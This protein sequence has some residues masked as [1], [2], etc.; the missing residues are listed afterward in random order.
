M[1]EA[2]GHNR[3][4]AQDEGMEEAQAQG[5]EEAQ[6]WDKEEVEVGEEAVC[7][8][9]DQV[10]VGVELPRCLKMPRRFQRRIPTTFPRLILLLCV[11]RVH[12]SSCLM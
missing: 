4:G 3:E 5:R 9:L 6:H 7:E 8:G 12:M 10:G 11:L 1:E 2:Q